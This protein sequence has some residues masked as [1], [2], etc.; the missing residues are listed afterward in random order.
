[1]NKPIRSTDFSAGYAT[2]ADT[3]LAFRCRGNEFHCRR[4]AE[5]ESVD[6]TLLQ[7]SGTHLVQWRCNIHAIESSKDIGEDLIA[8]ARA[9][10]FS[11]L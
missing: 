2:P 8:L 9:K 4:A 6:L 11:V 5:I 3:T 1:M 7:N 10:N